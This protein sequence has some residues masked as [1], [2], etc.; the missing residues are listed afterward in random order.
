MKDLTK[1][2]L[3]VI[4]QLAK[5]PLITK[6]GWDIENGMTRITVKSTIGADWN[7]VDAT[8]GTVLKAELSELEY[9]GIPAKY[10]NPSTGIEEE[11]H[12]IN[13]NGETLIWLIMQLAPAKWSPQ[14][15]LR[16]EG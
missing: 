10:T 11:M 7:A 14:D 16:Q 1:D 15:I 12:F 8:I 3:F 6:V 9:M 13:F 2:Q 4:Q 5:S